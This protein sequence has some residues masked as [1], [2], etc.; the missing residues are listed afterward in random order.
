[1]EAVARIRPS[2]DDLDS[3]GG[4]EIVSA[5]I[6]ALTA[7]RGPDAP[8]ALESLARERDLAA[9]RLARRVLRESNP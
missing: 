5:A 9:G 8:L 3:D 2:D 4:D 7:M 1:M 6:R